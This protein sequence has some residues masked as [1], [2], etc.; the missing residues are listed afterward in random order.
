VTAAGERFWASDLDDRDRTVLEAG[1]G[2]IDFTPDV[3]VVGGGIMGVAAALACERAGLGSVQL[4]EASILGGGATGGSAGLLQP[5]PHHGSDPAALVDLG[6]AGLGRWKDL[7]QTVQ[8]GVGL[9]G[10]DWIGLAPHSDAFTRDPPPTVRWLDV[11]QVAQLIPGLAVPTNGAFIANQARLNPQRALARLAHQLSHAA[12]GIAAT[13][14]TVSGRHI[15][16]FSTT[17]GTI[18][19]GI[20]I[21]ATG[22]PPALEGL[23]LAVPADWVKGHL[24]VS[25]PADIRLPGMVAPVAAPIEGGRLLVGGTLDVDDSSPGVREEVIAGLRADLTAALPAAVRVGVSHRWCCWRPHHPDGLPVIDQ[26]PDLDNAW[27]TSGHYRTGLLMGPA[28]ADLL[29]EWITTGRRPPSAAPF[30]LA[31]FAADGT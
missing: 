10:Q 19:P 23:R 18:R 24:L 26:I 8:G 3:L 17:A 14:V 13:G 6:R 20:V 25:E 5:E 29:V 30:A 4:I 28:T 2:P 11:D 31:R 7:E 22:G 9:V 16:D 15:T 27:L 21:F 1:R 12:T